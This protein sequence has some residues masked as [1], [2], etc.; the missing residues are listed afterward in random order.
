[1]AIEFFNISKFIIFLNTCIF[2]LNI[3]AKSHYE[4]Y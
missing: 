1:M 3:Q 2:V 4:N